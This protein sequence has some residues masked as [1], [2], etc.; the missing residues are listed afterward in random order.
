[1][2]PTNEHEH[3]I[4]EIDTLNSLLRGQLAA[5]ETYDQAINKF[6]D[7]QLLADLQAIREEHLEAEIILREKVLELGGEPV[8]AAGPWQTCAA[9]MAGESKSMGLA[10][11][12]A[13]LQQGEEQSINELEDSLHQEMNNDSKNLIRSNFLPQGRKHVEDLNRL[14]GGKA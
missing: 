3:S 5:V 9:A 1:M 8:D 14:M 10:T 7:P 11:A 6:E 4:S 2:S 12:L 13:A